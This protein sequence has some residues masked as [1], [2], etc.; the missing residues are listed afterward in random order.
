MPDVIAVSN[1]QYGYSEPDETGKREVLTKTVGDKLTEKDFGEDGLK[2]L[3]ACGSAVDMSGELQELVAIPFVDEQTV[4][5][6]RLLA[7]AGK[8]VLVDTSNPQNRGVPDPQNTAARTLE[9]DNERLRQ[10]LADMKASQESSKAAQKPAAPA[11]SH[12]A[13]AKK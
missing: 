2:A 3:I 10:E 9:E 11:V 7:K 4:E 5:R 8:P 6:D 13:P 12:Q 1:I